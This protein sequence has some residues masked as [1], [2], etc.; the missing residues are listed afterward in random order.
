MRFSLLAASA[1]IAAV[2]VVSAC[3][4][5]STAPS[6]NA[7]TSTGVHM[8]AHNGHP[9]WIRPAQGVKRFTGPT[10]GTEY[11]FCFYVEPG[12]SGPYVSTSDGSSPLYNSATITKNKSGKDAKKF[13]NYFYPSPG[14]PTSQY[15]TYKGKVKKVQPVKYTDNYCIG[16]S[17]S[18][19]ANGSGAVL[20]L[21]I[22]LEP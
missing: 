17:P 21:G 15:I 8:T 3:N 4:N 6:E 16:F 10:C 1:A 14:D 13:T 7:M 20:H 19:C 12:N 9:L 11:N 5:S 22:A 2:L 18:E